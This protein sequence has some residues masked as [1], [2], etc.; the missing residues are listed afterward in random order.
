MR[1]QELGGRNGGS[2]AAKMAVFENEK[3]I[4]QRHTDLIEL[5]RTGCVGQEP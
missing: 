3:L 2:Q 5:D 1:Q 4:C